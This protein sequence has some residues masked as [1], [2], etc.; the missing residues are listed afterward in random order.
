MDRLGFHYYPDKLHY[1]QADINK[2][3]P[4]FIEMGISW[5]VLDAPTEFAIPEFFIKELINSNIRPILHF[6]LPLNG[7]SNSDIDIMLKSYT[8]WGVKHFLF[9]DKPNLQSSWMP[10][11]WTKYNPVEKFI[12]FYTPLAN[13]VLSHNA[14][15]LFPPLEP[16]GDFWDTAFLRNSLQCLLNRGETDILSNLIVSCY[17]SP[18]NKSLNWG[19]GG[20]ERWPQ[21][22]PYVKNVNGEDHFGFRIFDWY[23]TIVKAILVQSRPIFLLGLDNSKHPNNKSQQMDIV[24]LLSGDK[25]E[26][27]APIPDFILGG[28]FQIPQADP[29]NKQTSDSVKNSETIVSSLRKYI[30]SKDISKGNTY[31]PFYIDH[32][33]LLPTFDWGVADWH[34][35][36]IRPFIQKH[37]PTIG[38]SLDEALHAK[39]VTVIGSNQIFPESTLRKL[40]NNGI[41][42]H[43]INGNGT[44]IATLLAKL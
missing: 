28:A 23:N 29:T 14:L 35:E 41:I 24:K 13:K 37:K 11:L 32:Y 3:L 12:D 18:R 19:L 43:R 4:L 38:F 33:L 44:E 26:G 17:A 7:K 9:F 40:R 6:K 10:S 1:T 20:Q 27:I 34:L 8:K 22:R 36:V 31:S 15:P 16:G 21:S 42:V 2:W 5:L 30:T 25:V 39:R